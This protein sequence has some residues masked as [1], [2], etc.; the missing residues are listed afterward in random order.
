MTSSFWI[1]LAIATAMAPALD[2]PVACDLRE[3]CAVQQLPDRAPGEERRDFRCHQLASDGHGGTDFRIR[4]FAG[5]RSRAI[6]VRAAAAGRVLRVRDHMPDRNIRTG[7]A[8]D[9]GERL[10]GNAVVI[11]HGDGWETQYSH[12][13]AGSV[14]VSP[15]DEVERGATIGLVGSSGNAEFPHLHFEVRHLGAAVDPFDGQPLSAAP[16]CDSAIQSMWRDPA[17]RE[18]ARPNEI[19]AL[20]LA[21]SANGAR[22][23]RVDET[24]RPIPDD[25]PA[26]VVW[27]DVA[28]LLGESS[29]RFLLTAPDGTT[30]VDRTTRLG[31]DSV[32]WLAFAGVRRPATGWARGR[33]VATYSL[34]HEG[35]IQKKVLEFDLRTSNFHAR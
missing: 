32:S 35:V 22:A 15:G 25:P 28:G 10:A 2:L 9:M 4:A 14:A 12:L 24:P 29:Q 31:P 3:I 26:L 33:Y 27:A 17:A 6:G 23:R 34:E 8:G 1:E 13:R 20:G 11:D 5:W 7:G 18:W 19:L 16:R 21:D 30:L